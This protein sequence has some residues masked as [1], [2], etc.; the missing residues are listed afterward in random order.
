MDIGRATVVELPLEETQRRWDETT[1]EWPI[2]HAVLH[3]VTRD[4]FMGRHASNHIQVAYGHDGA[5][6]DRAMAV[7]AAMAEQLG[8]DVHLC[9]ARPD[10]SPL[11]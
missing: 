1:P 3:G 8:I 2:M 5:G 4:Q 9:G 6:A 10:G 7:K 11:L